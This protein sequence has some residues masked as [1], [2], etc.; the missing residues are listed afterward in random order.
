MRPAGAF[1]GEEMV[2]STDDENSSSAVVVD[3]IVAPGFGTHSDA[4]EMY[5]VSCTGAEKH[6]WHKSGNTHPRGR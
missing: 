1:D 5:G 2:N 4:R 6:K 3:R